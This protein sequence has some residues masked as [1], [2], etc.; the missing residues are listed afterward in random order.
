[1][2]KVIK[3]VLCSKDLFMLIGPFTRKFQIYVMTTDLRV[4]NILLCMRFVCWIPKAKST[5]LI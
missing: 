5:H 4:G 2:E 1:M 3:R